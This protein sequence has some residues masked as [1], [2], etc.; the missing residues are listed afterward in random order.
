M[1]LT[2]EQLLLVEQCRAY[3]P[4]PEFRFHETRKF[5]IDVAFPQHMLAVEID[6]GGWVQGRHS[7]GLGIAKDA[8]KSA[9]LAI[10]GYRLIRCT[11]EQVRKGIVLAWVQQAIGVAA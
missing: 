5:R 9:L 8:E 1:K 7:R 11:P 10:C 6:G 3:G 2:L 4:V